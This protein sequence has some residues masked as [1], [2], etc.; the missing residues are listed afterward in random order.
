MSVLVYNSRSAS[1]SSPSYPGSDL[2]AT[3]TIT[4]ESLTIGDGDGM[5]CN[6]FKRDESMLPVVQHIGDIVRLHRLKVGA[7]QGLPQGLASPGFC[8]I[9]FDGAVG[10]GYEPRSGTHKPPL[11]T[12]ADRMRIDRLRD[13]ARGRAAAVGPDRPLQ[14]PSPSVAARVLVRVDPQLSP[15]ERETE[16]QRQRQ[17]ERE[18]Q[19]VRDEED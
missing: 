15:D 2:C 19:R 18:R 17:R 9:V 16:R 1:T 4:D 6:I 8:G 12:A 5:R 3:L 13:W 11:V 7:H 10:G 14:L